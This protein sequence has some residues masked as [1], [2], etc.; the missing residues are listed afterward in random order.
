V[1]EVPSKETSSI[2]ID[3][4]YVHAGSEEDEGSEVPILLR[5]HRTKGP[6]VIT[7]EAVMAEVTERQTT[8]C[9]PIPCLLRSIL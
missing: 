2:T 3:P 9:D 4:E 5:S 6:A 1:I 7:M 8:R